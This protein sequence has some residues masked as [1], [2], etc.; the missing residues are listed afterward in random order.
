[1]SNEDQ[2]PKY[3]ELLQIA[4]EIEAGNWCQGTFSL[5]IGSQTKRCAVGWLNYVFRPPFTSKYLSVEAAVKRAAGLAVDAPLEHWND[6]F[7]RT[8]G[9]VAEAFR[10]AA[11][12]V[13]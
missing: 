8:R 6:T 11:Y 9:Q 5:D 7:G 3:P 1:M 2:I 12:D 13:E 4:D 10:K